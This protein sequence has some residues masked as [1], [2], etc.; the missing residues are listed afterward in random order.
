MSVC[1]IDRECAGNKVELFYFGEDSP[2]MIAVTEGDENPICFP[3][4]PDKAMDAFN[5]PYV[6]MPRNKSKELQEAMA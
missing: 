3:V 2:L 4:E 5:H 1:L 6:Y